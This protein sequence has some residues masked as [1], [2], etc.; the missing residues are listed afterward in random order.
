MLHMASRLRCETSAVR[1]QA[2]RVDC[3]PGLSSEGPSFLHFS[4]GLGHERESLG[5]GFFKV[6]V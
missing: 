3:E 2:W 5:L 6:L 1:W 4:I